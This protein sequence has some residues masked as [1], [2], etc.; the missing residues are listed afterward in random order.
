[1]AGYMHWTI[2]KHVGLQ[3]TDKYCERKPERVINVKSATVM[4]DVLVITDRIIL[5]NR[6]DIVL[7]TDRYCHTR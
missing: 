7:L 2:C 3:I 6:P 1:M 4:L 5:A